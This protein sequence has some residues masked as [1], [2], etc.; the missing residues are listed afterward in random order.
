VL[1]RAARRLAASGSDSPR[2]DA[3]LLLAHSTG[4]ARATLLAHPERPVPVDA[5]AGFEA[6]VRR[7]EAAEPVA[8]LVGRREFYGRVFRTDRRALIPRPETELLVELGLAA[9]G[10]GRA[11]GV[12]PVVVDVGTGSG[13][14]AVT[15]A[16]ETGARVLAID[17]SADALALA[18]ENASLLG[19][20]ARVRLVRADLLSAVRGP[21]HLVLANLPY[22]PAGR[23][24]AP[25]LVDHEPRVA[26]FAGPGGTELTERLLHE[27]AALLAPGG[28]LALELDGPAQAQRLVTVARAL[29]PGAETEVRRDGAGR[30]R[31]LVVRLR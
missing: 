4:W 16:A 8:Y 9:V 31:A 29:Y 24:L 30:D 1:E 7:R 19:Q 5:A 18:A 17:L 23:P 21:V 27:A 10:R 22:V 2:L 13:A 11:R 26:L 25:E 15:L 3:Q 12:E 6:L 20:R 14:L 28:E